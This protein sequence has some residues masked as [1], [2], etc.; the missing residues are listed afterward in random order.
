MSPRLWRA[1]GTLLLD[2]G[3]PG[4]AAPLLRE[5]VDIHREAMPAG[6]RDRIDAERALARCETALR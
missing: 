4:L 1:L 5:A 2:R 3:D 6:D